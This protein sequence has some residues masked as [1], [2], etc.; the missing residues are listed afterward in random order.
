MGLE[1]SKPVC[2]TLHKVAVRMEEHNVK[3]WLI[4]GT[5]KVRGMTLNWI[6][7]SICPLKKLC[8]GKL[9]IRGGIHLLN[10]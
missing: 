6:S 4:V 10:N 7:I 9:N 5:L 2:A 1:N 3:V 8:F